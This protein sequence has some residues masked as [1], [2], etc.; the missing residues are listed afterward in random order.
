MPRHKILPVA[1]FIIAFI[2]I[3]DCPFA[4]ASL[5]AKN[6]QLSFNTAAGFQI[7]KKNPAGVEKN[8]N[9]ALQIVTNDR[10]VFLSP[11]ANL[12][13]AAASFSETLQHFSCITTTRLLL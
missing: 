2:Y 10:A 11:A 7:K 13:T 3:T 12:P 8:L 4:W 5:A 6:I 1:I 9:V